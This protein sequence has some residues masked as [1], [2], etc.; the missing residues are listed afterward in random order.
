MYDF[1]ES[2]VR[3]ALRNVCAPDAVFRLSHPFETTVG[4]D[5]YV[6][7]VYVPLLRAV[8]DMERR[9]AIVMAGPTPEGHDWIGCCGFY[10]GTFAAPWLDIPATGHLVHMRFHEFYRIVDDKIVE[11]QALWD[12]PELM[13]QAG[14]WPMVP[15]LG[16]EWSVPG[17]ASNDG[18]VPGPYDAVQGQATCQHIIDMLEHLTRHPSKGGPEVMEIERFWHPRMNWYGPAGI[19]TARGM[20]GFRNW[21]QIPFLAAMPDRGQNDDDLRFHFFGDRNYAAVT[22]WPNMAQSIS[23]GGWLGIA[24]VGKK[25]EMRSLDFWRLENGLIRENW[26][27]VDLMHMYDQIGVDVLARMREFNKARPGFDP[28][29]GVTL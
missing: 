25:V 8:P 28:E 29:T 5:A 4:V 2:G 24:P 1:D 10:C 11:M 15:S 21:H 23:H 6:D 16:R 20:R 26:V 3:A 14:A 27:L 22:G 9:E 18:M 13:M 17:P 19:G 7:K 12:I